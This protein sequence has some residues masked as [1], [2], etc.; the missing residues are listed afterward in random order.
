MAA[1]RTYLNYIT[2]HIDIAP[3]NSQ[4]ELDAATMIQT[5]MSEH[6]LAVSQQDVATPALGTLIHDAL[7]LLMF[8][9]VLLSGFVG[10]V[11]GHIGVLLCIVCAVII[12]CERAGIHVVSTLGSVA[13]SQNIIGFHKGSGPLCI[14]GVRPIVIVA[15]YDTPREEVLTQLQLAPYAARLKKL[16][17]MSCIVAI[18]CVIMQISFLAFIPDAVRRV[19]WLLGVLCAIPMLAVGVNTVY[20]KFSV[21]TEGAN[22]NKASLAAM[23]SIIDTLKP[24]NDSAKQWQT[25]VGGAAGTA[26][27]TA[28][29]N[30]EVVSAA[31][32]EG[33]AE[34]G[35]AA[36]TEVEVAD[37]ASARAG[38]RGG[39]AGVEV[40]APVTVDGEA[41]AE[42]SANDLAQNKDDVDADDVLA[43]TANKQ[44][45]ST[46]TDA[47]GTDDSA[48]TKAV[49]AAAAVTGG[50]AL[51]AANVT[52]VVNAANTTA[53]AA[54][55]NNAPVCLNAHDV[56]RMH[57]F[58]YD[59]AE[60][61][62]RRGKDALLA[63]GL[64]PETCSVSYDVDITPLH[65][66]LFV[67]PALPE[68]RMPLTTLTPKDAMETA[69][70]DEAIEEDAA[71]I[72][73][74]L[75]AARARR[76]RAVVMTSYEE[77]F[78]E[79]AWEPCDE[80]EL[81]G[82]GAKTADTGA[83]G[84]DSDAADV[85]GVADTAASA[86]AGARGTH[87]AKDEDK[88][89]SGAADV[90]SPDKTQAY[91]PAQIIETKTAE[92]DAPAADDSDAAA[93]ATNAAREGLSAAAVQEAFD[94]ERQTVL[95]E[96]NTMARRAALFDL[97]NPMEVPHDPFATGVSEPLS[98]SDAAAAGDA[99]AAG[100]A[101]DNAVDVADAATRGTWKGG[102]TT[103]KGLRVIEGGKNPGAMQHD[104]DAELLS[105]NNNP[106][107]PGADAPADAPVDAA[108]S[109]AFRVVEGG[110]GAD[111]EHGSGTAFASTNEQNGH[112]AKAPAAGDG[113]SLK[114]N[115]FV[116]DG[117]VELF[118]T[119]AAADAT[120]IEARDA[121]TPA[122]PVNAAEVLQ[123]AADNHPEN[124]AEQKEL[125]AKAKAARDH[126]DEVD[127][128][129]SMG[130]DELRCHDIWFVAAGASELG[131]AGMHAFLR[132]HKRDIR[133]C[134]LINLDAVGAG[135]LSIL[136]REG[137][138]DTR[139][140][141]RRISRLCKRVAENLHIELDEAPYDYAQTDATEAMRSSVRSLTLMGLDANGLPAFRGT[142][143]DV[144]ENIDDKQVKQVAQLV[145]EV[146]RRA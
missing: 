126:T 112:N 64:L 139:A 50:G 121:A 56:A 37:V 78:P 114:N 17:P 1:T 38:E 13:Q 67:E 82:G 109:G 62:T 49:A 102:A 66:E 144:A 94:K 32:D 141:D 143:E 31:E 23:L 142:N 65:P 81:P 21:C 60:G 116:K 145:S 120:G 51:E 8:V 9:A 26:A 100:D 87:A 101:A 132:D 129:L 119:P 28:G 52:D 39:T 79:A 131:C 19:F 12:F 25:G 128:V 140:C 18:V 77:Q 105:D 46:V 135:S 5:L 33:L 99:V 92:V 90:P 72:S 83:A 14:K 74:T 45:A 68:E 97:P 133:G 6:N 40:A 80:S 110:A 29:A 86:H 41:V 107:M 130:N 2:K 48:A 124:F 69:Q 98:S 3:A 136:S 125:D 93:R 127:A 84:A 59:V 122:A 115:P 117:V 36:D 24:G 54:A 123:E 137:L 75:R 27:T 53:G 61:S 55:G 70:S 96:S 146:I 20:K 104:A 85:A 57:E 134:F 108:R 22:S 89:A 47:E 16:V 35:K 91:S 11:V 113:L 111:D 58:T 44:D 76:T 10:T 43:A 34:G 118:Q 103:R 106:G 95:D 4:E 30:I 138:D 71:K 42:A 7:L 88:A 73:E 63:L 15:H